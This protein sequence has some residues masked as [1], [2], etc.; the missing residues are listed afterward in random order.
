MYAYLSSNKME[1][2]SQTF[3]CCNVLKLIDLVALLTVTKILSIL[4]NSNHAP[5]ICTC[6][7][8]VKDLGIE[9]NDKSHQ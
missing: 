9:D 1:I 4:L 3:A 5:F 8:Y 6:I 2:S 7:R